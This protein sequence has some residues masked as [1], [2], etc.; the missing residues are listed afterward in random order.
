[1]PKVF[2]SLSAA[3]FILYV[4]A[5]ALGLLDPAPTPDRHVLLAVLALLL[6]CLSQ[7][8]AFTYLAVT[9]KVLAQ[10][11]HFGKLSV[12]TLLA[13][14][15]IKKRFGRH[16]ALMMLAVG[17]ATATGASVWRAGDPDRYHSPAVLALLIVFLWVHVRQF[18]LVTENARLVSQTLTQYSVARNANPPSPG[19]IDRMEPRS[20]PFGVED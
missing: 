8:L 3:N 14:K 10:A 17:A 6:T 5:A 1:M 9:G 15:E 2:A 7:V 13:A 19:K 4:G 12:E 11:L 16:I 18:L 20:S